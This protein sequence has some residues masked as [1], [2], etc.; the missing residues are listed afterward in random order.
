MDTKVLL[1]AACALAAVV[2]LPVRA[3]SG[4]DTL[5]S[6][7]AA[8]AINVAFAGD[9]LPFSFVDKDTRP[10]GYSIELC[11][12]VI[13]GIGRAVGEPNL[14]INWKVG[15]TA[16]RLAMVADGSADLECGN[17]TPTLGRMKSVDF[18]SM[19]FV[20]TSGVMVRRDAHATRFGELGGKKIAVIGGT[21]TEVR[22]AAALKD[23]LVNAQVIRV[24][25]AAEAIAMLD[26]GSA[27]AFA[28]DKLKLVGSALLSKDSKA[29]AVLEENLSL[30]PYAFAVPRNDTAF[31]V[32]VNRALAQTYAGSEL[33]TI[34]KRWFGSLGPPSGLLLSL[35]ALHALPE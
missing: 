21:T 1:I 6:I 18:S 11:N 26:A 29:L 24:R 16:E 7:R 12:K 35:Y 8:K 33:Q 34:F 5:G 2:T 28:S 4:T 19:V 10:A 3:Q 15:T 14:K 17:T 13:A 25:D 22:L 9:S 20:D 30:E 32:E 27:D 31:R 23:R